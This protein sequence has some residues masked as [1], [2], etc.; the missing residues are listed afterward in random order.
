[1]RVLHNRTF[2]NKY[3][4]WRETSTD[5]ALRVQVKKGLCCMG[6]VVEIG[7]R[8]YPVEAQYKKGDIVVFQRNSVTGTSFDADFVIQNIDVLG[9]VDS[10]GYLLPLN[11]VVLVVP[12]NERIHREKS[13]LVTVTKS[14]RFNEY[15]KV[16]KLGRKCENLKIGDN[17]IL[18]PYSG[19]IVYIDDSFKINNEFDGRYNI[20][21]LYRE[22]SILAKVV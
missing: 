1:M 12:I 20:G 8:K 13:G 10:N 15:G 3:E 22:K 11:D 14:D 21:I 2:I 18:D 16:V 4:P 6:T 9:V 7:S 17:V 19:S 5:I